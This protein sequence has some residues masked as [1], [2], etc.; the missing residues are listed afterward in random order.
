MRGVLDTKLCDKVCQC[1]AEGRWFS[2]NTPVSSTNKTDRHDITKKLL[3]LALNT[4]PPTL[5]NSVT[6]S[7]VFGYDV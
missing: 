6:Y 5:R 7:F 4:I 1:L 2:P 3:K